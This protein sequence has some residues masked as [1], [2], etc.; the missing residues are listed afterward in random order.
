MGMGMEGV[1]MNAAQNSRAPERQRKSIGSMVCEDG[2]MGCEDGNM[3]CE[4]R[5]M[6]CE[7]EVVVVCQDRVVIY[8]VAGSAN[9]SYSRTCSKRRE[10]TAQTDR[11]ANPTSARPPLSYFCIEFFKKFAV[12]GLPDLCEYVPPRARQHSLLLMVAIHETDASL[13]LWVPVLNSSVRH[14]Q[15]THPTLPT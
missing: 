1:R 11:Q 7:D 13:F 6:G 5:N 12:C 3:V 10:G 9:T 15:P 2:N 4:D 14:P 8:T